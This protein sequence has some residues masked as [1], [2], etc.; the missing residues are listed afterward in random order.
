MLEGFR[1]PKS[2]SIVRERVVNVHQNRYG[3]VHSRNFFHHETGRCETQLRSAVGFG[4]FLF[5]N[6]RNEESV[7]SWYM[8]VRNME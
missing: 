6:M 5:D 1:S 7:R 8:L 4:D 3:W 2:N